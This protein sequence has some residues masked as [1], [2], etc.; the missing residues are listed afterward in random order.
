MLS[1]DAKLANVCVFSLGAPYHGAMKARSLT[2]GLWALGFLSLGTSLVPI[3]NGEQGYDT[4]PLWRAVRALLTGG[5]VYTEKGAGD[6]LYPPSAL[7]MLSP[8]GALSLPWAGRVFFVVDLATI[9]VA[10]AILLNVF[11]LQWRG[12]PGAIALLAISLAW[13]VLFTLDAGNVNGPLVL[14]LALF[15]SAAS[16]GRWSTAGI[17]FGLTLALKPL[18]APLLIVL[19]LYRRWKAIA[20]A[21]AVPVC[22]S[23]LVVLAAPTTR[24]FFDRTLPLL[25]RGQ[26]QEIQDVSIAIASVAERLSIPDPVTTAMRFAVLLIT[27]VLLWR[28]WRSPDI[29]E[30]RRLVELCSIA[31]VGAFLTSTFAFPHYGIFLLPLAVSITDPFSPHRDWLTWGALFCVASPI[32]WQLDLLPERMNDVLAERFTFA[33]VLLLVCFSLALRRQ[34]AVGV[35]AHRVQALDVSARRRKV[36]VQ[37]RLSLRGR[38]VRRRAISAGESD[39]KVVEDHQSLSA[40]DERR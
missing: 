22:L 27:G 14:G 7:A 12:L 2:G 1:E 9:L 10:T 25:F 18:L 23:G 31:L 39:G 28:R 15:L 5:T 8:L 30:P 33:L 20:I 24:H 11:G 3:V 16:R 35:A 26:N 21:I 36:P 4:A 19:M 34:P 37:T 17:W 13:P 29:A 40:E 6:F 32:G 38:L